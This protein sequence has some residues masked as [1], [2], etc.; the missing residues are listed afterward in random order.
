MGIRHASAPAHQPWLPVTD[1]Q[2]VADVIFAH[3]VYT[4]KLP[5][6]WQVSI[7][8]LP[9][10]SGDGDPLFPFGFGLID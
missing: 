2:G 1:G 7:D 8:Q 10:E 4:G 5:K 3:L 9:V 6:T